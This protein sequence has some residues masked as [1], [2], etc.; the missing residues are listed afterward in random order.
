MKHRKSLYWLVTCFIFLVSCFSVKEK[1]ADLAREVQPAEVPATVPPADIFEIPKPDSS[2]YTPIVLAQGFDE[3]LGMEIL[4]KNN[5][6][7]IE[8]KG[9]VKLYNASEK[10]LKTIYHFNVFSGIEDGLLGIALDPD[11]IKNKWVYFYYAVGG[12][13]AM[14]RLSRIELDGE[15]LNI[16]T[17]KTLL[18]IPTQ[19][20]YCCHSGGAIAFGPDKLLYLST[21][22]NTNAEES[23]GYV[24]IDERPG[25]ELTDDQATAANT[26][27]L[28]G[29]ILRIKPEDDGT[30]SI[31]SGNLFAEGTPLARP[32]IYVMGLRNPYKISVDMKTGYLY[33]GDVGPATTVPGEEGTLSYDEINQAKKPGFYGWPYFLGNNEAFPD[34]NFATKKEGP[35]FNPVKPLNDSPNNTGLKVL[36]SAQPAMIWYGRLASKRFPLVGKGGASA[37]AGPVYY[38]ELYPDSKVKLSAYYDGKL[39]IY[40][41]VRRWIMTVTL[42]KDGN[43][44]SMEPFLKHLKIA[45]PMDMKIGP[46]GALYLLEYGTN[47][48][49]KNADARLVRLEYSEG[50]RK[51]IAN[52]KATELYGAAPF[53]VNLSATGS[54]D[55]DKD[56]QLSYEWLIGEKKILA[57]ELKHTFD[58]PGVYDVLLNVSDDKGAVGNS[59][60]QVKV[61]NTPPVINIFSNANRTFFW[62]NGVFDYKVEVKD[63][64]D[65]TIDQSRV[66]VS[67][68]F[69]EHGR[70]FASGFMEDT[71]DAK[72]IRGSQLV[73]TLDCRA[74]HSKD[75][76][77]L[78]PSYR[79]IAK[80]YSGKNDAPAMLINKI[81]KG[82]SGNWGTREMPPHLEMSK[83]DVNEIVS[84]ILSVNDQKPKLPALGSFKQ[85]EHIGK[86]NDGSYLLTASYKDKGANGI[87]PILSRKY[88][89][90]RSPRIEIEDFDEG[91]LRIA[92]VTTAF[93]SY[94]R[95]NNRSFVKFRQFDLTGI[96]KVSYRVQST[97]TGGMLEVRL[98][99]LN[100]KLISTVNIPA[101]EE[102]DAKIGWKN[103]S[104]VVTATKGIH[105]LYFTFR[106]P[107][108]DQ[109][110]TLFTIDWLELLRE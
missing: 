20:R 91:N 48:F 105:D 58:K 75:M 76:A 72:Y 39:F 53:T 38:S 43:Y 6:L 90:L 37:F 92:T 65:K 28:R 33:W 7:F 86:G 89:T 54:I 63:Q 70:D 8:R 62:D 52:I 44:V 80:R 2:R 107:E 98:D 110:K 21:G 108:T 5:I 24:P 30:Y 81:I 66:N 34:Y 11:F 84:Y 79:E 41:W 50:N 67:L 102:P 51:P 64:E 23:E 19:R 25:R 96:K 85:I 29:K 68:S 27:D 101:G 95:A 49:S 26:N 1:S 17:E 13:K 46:D 42:D 104:G 32:E 88:I 9:A 77:S 78:G 60:V 12:A 31:P 22:D 93:I 47:W 3:P 14:N 4:P 109:Y 71:E 45:A 73:A 99:S 15:T 56:D 83:A 61:G 82:G 103:V 97:G 59:S 100:G 69:F 36:P 94:A 55:H 57:A 74:C 10:V 40:D 16:K 106:N 35:K 18:E 87:E